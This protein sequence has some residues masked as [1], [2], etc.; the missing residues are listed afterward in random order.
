MLLLLRLCLRL[1]GRVIRCS[2]RAQAVRRAWQILPQRSTTGRMGCCHGSS[3][4]AGTA[5][6]WWQ[7]RRR[8]GMCA[9]VCVCVWASWGEGDTSWHQLVSPSPHLA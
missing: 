2:P 8:M 5:Q 1:R 3:R 9:C 4:T 6:T 7:A